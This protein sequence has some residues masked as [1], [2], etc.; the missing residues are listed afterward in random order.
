MPAKTRM[1]MTPRMTSHRN[2][3]MSILKG[4]FGAVPAKQIYVR[5]FRMTA[6]MEMTFGVNESSPFPFLRL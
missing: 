1:A 2:R 4:H 5:L 3:N 6:Q